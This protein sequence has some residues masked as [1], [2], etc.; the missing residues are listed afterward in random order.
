MEESTQSPS[1]TTSLY[2]HAVRWGLIAGAVSV[3]LTV[4]YY[5]IDVGLMVNWKV[6]LLTFAIYIGFAIYAGIQYRGMVGGYL[7]FGK[8][9]QH[10]FVLFAIS[11]LVSTAFN[12]VLYTLIDSELAA[13][14][15]DAALAQTESMLRGFGTPEDAIE[16]A[17]EESR[18][19]MA[20]Q[21]TAFGMIKSYLWM[22]IGCAVL[23]LITSL[24]VRKNEPVEM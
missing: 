13:K 3:I 12:I 22:L 21:F 10:G 20:D 1:E 6:G 7:S 17:M 9:F 19:K 11:A 15:T 24:F 4:I 23:A 8:A 16:K 18:V 14:V 5:V 2:Q